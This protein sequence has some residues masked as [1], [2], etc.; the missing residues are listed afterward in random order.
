VEVENNGLNA[1]AQ[2]AGQATLNGT[3]EGEGRTEKACQPDTLSDH[4][5][6]LLEQERDHLRDDRQR[7]AEEIA[8][9]RAQLDRRGEGIQRRDHAEAELRRLLLSAQQLTHELAQQLEQKALPPGPVETLAPKGKVR[10][11][12]LWKRC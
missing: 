9:F 7:Q 4:R 6:D 11:W 2:R 1:Q 8:H 5:A 10:W 12:V 3:L